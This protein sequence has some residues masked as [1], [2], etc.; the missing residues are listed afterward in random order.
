MAEPRYS[1][2][3]QSLEE[4]RMFTLEYLALLIAAFAGFYG[5]IRLC[6]RL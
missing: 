2:S 6:D 4:N 1:A 3:G 5:L